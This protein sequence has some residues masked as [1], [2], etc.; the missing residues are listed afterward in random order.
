MFHL[1]I[2]RE[3]TTRSS[4]KYCNFALGFRRYWY[5]MMPIVRKVFRKYLFVDFEKFGNFRIETRQLSHRKS[6]TFHLGMAEEPNK[7]HLN[8]YGDK[9]E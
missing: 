5:K 6:V 2:Y 8:I 4:D 7:D 1:I 9:G 3:L